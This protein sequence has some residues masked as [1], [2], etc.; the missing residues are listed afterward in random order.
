MSSEPPQLSNGLVDLSLVKNRY[1]VSIDV[2]WA[3]GGSHPDF[4]SWLVNPTR[5]ASAL[6]TVMDQAG[7][8]VSD[9][10]RFKPF[11]DEYASNSRLLVSPELQGLAS[12]LRM[13][14]NV[15]SKPWVE[16]RLHNRLTIARCIVVTVAA[17]AWLIGM[18]TWLV[19]SRAE[20]RREFLAAGMCPRCEYSIRG[21]TNPACPECGESLS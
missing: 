7:T 16:G 20:L 2:T 17:S 14:T 6:V 3:V 21:L 4:G 9:V 11:V 8:V 15:W 1:S 18:I 10:A 5:R 19:S 12:N 13:G